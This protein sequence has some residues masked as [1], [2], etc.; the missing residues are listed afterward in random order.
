M[1]TGCWFL[2]CSS[3]LWAVA[4]PV[5]VYVSEGCVCVCVCVCVSGGWREITGGGV[6]VWGLEGGLHII[7]T[8]GYRLVLPFS[9]ILSWC[10]HTKWLY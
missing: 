4:R 9:S 5:F 8:K 3:F 7:Y 2:L 10:V 6:C 1:E